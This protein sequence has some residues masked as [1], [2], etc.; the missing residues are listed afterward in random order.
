MK[1]PGAFKWL[2]NLINKAVCCLSEAVQSS[3]GTPVEPPTAQEIADA[4][5]STETT[6][7]EAISGTDIPNNS[8]GFSLPVTSVWSVTI[9]NEGMDPVAID[10]GDGRTMTI[11][12][13]GTRT[14][15]TGHRMIDV[16]SLTIDTGANS[17]ADAI[18][19]V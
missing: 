7:T 2:E 4:N 13:P 19:E 1:T 10:F 9:S 17:Q 3:G 12:G 16:S 11:N 15:G 6:L 5:A 8:N 14:W 18:W